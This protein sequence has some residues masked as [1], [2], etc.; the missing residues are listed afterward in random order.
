MN[1]WVKDLGE[2]NSML[3]QTVHDLEKAAVSRV[4]LLEDKLQETSL[5]MSQNIL[6]S[7]KSEDVSTNCLNLVQTY[8]MFDLIIWLL[9]YRI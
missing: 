8:F 6:N 2:Q 5:N 1:D 9:Y 7:D 4:K 3:V